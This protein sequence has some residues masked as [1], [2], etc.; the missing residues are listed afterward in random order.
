V[1]RDRRSVVFV[2]A[3]VLGALVLFGCGGSSPGRPST[4]ARLRIVNPA[5]NAVS[6]QDVTVRVEL[7]R[8]HIVPASQVGGKPRADR[9][10]VHVSL[11]GQ[12][13]AMAYGTDQ[14]LPGVA[15]GRHTLQAE[16]VATDHL[17]FANRVVT[18]V[19]FTVR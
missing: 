6:G 17:P 15:P 2:A 10:H 18:A 4:P 11:D 5:P 7:E 16:F 9:G 8:A 3:L 1:E 19:T 13:V 14:V 12:I